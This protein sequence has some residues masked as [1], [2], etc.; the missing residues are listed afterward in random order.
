MKVAFRQAFWLV[1]KYGRTAMTDYVKRFK[2]AQW[3]EKQGR[4][5]PSILAGAGGKL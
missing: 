1:T 3:S 4:S 2:G 5:A